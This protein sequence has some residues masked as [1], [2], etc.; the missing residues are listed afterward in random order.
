[1][2]TTGNSGTPP[3][4]DQSSP[5]TDPSTGLMWTTSD[6]NA[7]LDFSGAVSYCKT[8]NRG[9]FPDWRLA[10][11]EELKGIFDPSLNVPVNRPDLVALHIPGVPGPAHIKGY[12]S[13][14]GIE[15]SNSGKPPSN[16]QTFDF[17]QG[18][19]K[20]IKSNKPHAQMRA[21]CVR[22][23]KV[24]SSSSTGG[25]AQPQSS[26][27]QSQPIPKSLCDQ[28]VFTSYS[29]L[30]N[31]HLY[32]IKVLGSPGPQERLFFFDEKG[33]Q[34]TDANAAFQLASSV[35]TYDNVVASPDARAGST[36]VS[37]ILGT[38][39]A[40]QNYS[41]VQ[42]LL[43]RSM[44]EALE[45][46]ATDGASLSKA[47]PN[48]TVGALKSQLLSAPKTILTLTAQRGLEESL[49][50]YRQLD[51]LLPPQDSTALNAV[52]LG[53][54]KSLYVQARTLELPYEALAVKLMPTQGS[55]LTNA[56]LKSAMSEITSG[57]LFSDSP[58]AA[59]NL[60]GILSLEKSL[61]DLAKSL[62]AFQ[63]YSQN[64]ALAVNLAAAN[65]NTITKWANGACQPCS[66]AQTTSSNNIALAVPAASASPSCDSKQVQL[67]T[68]NRASDFGIL[69]STDNGQT[70]TRIVND[71]GGIDTIVQRP[72]GQIFGG[73]TGALS[74]ANLNLGLLQTNNDG[75]N[76]TRMTRCSNGIDLS[77]VRAILSV[78]AGEMI[79][80]GGS[81][82][83]RSMDSG[84]TWVAI[85][86]GLTEGTN[87]NVQALA[88]SPSGTIFAATYDGVMRWNETT[89][90]WVRAGL[91]GTGIND[92][93][94]TSKGTLVAGSAGAG[95]YRSVDG[96][97]HWAKILLGSGRMWV[98]HLAIDS[99]GHLFAGASDQGIYRSDDDGATW[100]ELHIPATKPQ[101][102]ALAAGIQGEILAALGSCCPVNSVELLR[103]LDS[104]L[105]WKSILKIPGG[106]AAV[107]AVRV[108]QDRS[109]LV[110][111][112]TIGD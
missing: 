55:D 32:K 71:S 74:G 90:A 101:V 49:T 76:W 97:V 20:P 52:D 96:G 7:D 31:G 84:S 43:A 14:S 77:D 64:L 61:K 56:A 69:R 35:W 63:D 103:S 60:Q 26:S 36:R 85:N 38:S 86:R 8:L 39:K 10:E 102:Y 15:I 27:S 87:S 18:K 17:G 5:W 12:I 57:P 51:S 9:G 34:I 21:L 75:A 78:E 98:A 41:N 105:T 95:I 2:T 73:T 4:P 24:A 54:I 108:T 48:I 25:S 28:A 62:P 109:I 112:T 66:S 82:V 80:A 83:W 16:L 106:N 104:G 100:R 93:T 81:G 59:V 3:T 46:V 47:V 67:Q 44:V 13:V 1:M 91:A 29:V 19:V 42:D 88:K 70:W 33:A 110:G 30:S 111:L 72:T 23:S 58:T 37:G 50:K 53:R 94:V 89:N 92:L 40:L 99:R 11:I 65:E 22:N 45:A 6:S 68:G 79:I 107:G